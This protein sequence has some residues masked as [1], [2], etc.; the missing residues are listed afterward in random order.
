[1]LPKLWFGSD[2]CPRNSKCH[3]V[4][5]NEKK[6]REKNPSAFQ[7][8]T[9]PR[10][11]TTNSSNNTSH[12]NKHVPANGLFFF[13]LGLRPQHMEIPRLQLPAYTTA[14]A[15]QDPSH[16]CNLYHSSWQHWILNPLNKT[17]DQNHIFMD[18]SQ[19]HYHWA[20]MGTPLPMLLNLKLSHLLL[21]FKIFSLSVD[22]NFL[23]LP[24]RFVPQCLCASWEL[25]WVFCGVCLLPHL[26]YLLCNTR[27][28]PHLRSTPQLKAMQ[29]P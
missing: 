26:M 29:D 15:T 11:D 24:K 8:Q 21:P 4:D 16:I 12:Q 6:E 3:G 9:H 25:K 28:K 14:T 23:I 18:A 22:M 2:P 27:S 10:P 5:Q 20:T 17:R 1:V 7:P 13:F 19:V